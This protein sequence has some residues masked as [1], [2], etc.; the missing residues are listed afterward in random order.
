MKPSDA[1]ERQPGVL[2][3]FLNP[4]RVEERPDGRTW[5]LLE[6]LRYRT[7]R[8][9]LVTVPA[10]FVT[11]F[12]S[13]PRIFWPLVP[14]LG[15]YNRAT[16]L[17][18]WLYR[19]AQAPTTPGGWRNIARAEADR[20]LRAAMGDC[21]VPWLT[22]W[23]IYLGVRLGGWIVWRAHHAAPRF[24]LL[25]HAGHG[26]THFDLLLEQDTALAT[27][28]FD[29]SPTDFA[30]GQELRGVRL[31]DHR[32]LYLDYEG[33]VSNGRGQV[34]RL[35]GG[36]CVLREPRP[37]HLELMLHGRSWQG[38]FRL[39]RDAAGDGWSLTAVADLFG[40]EAGTLL[41]QLPG[42]FI[43]PP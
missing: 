39:E 15:R 43:F 5:R 1:P 14:P 17:H 41:G 31:S 7:R 27:W 33:P 28:Q 11:D 4:L 42:A 40:F 10:G 38:R 2:R 29:A 20:L 30:P 32:R 23:L 25:R 13:I 21:G 35:D 19:Q 22:R 18:D 12:A 8:G 24:A 6:E 9:E 3:E 37:D 26:P 36:T 16:V 34:T